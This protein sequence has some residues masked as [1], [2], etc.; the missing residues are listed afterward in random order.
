MPSPYAPRAVVC[1]GLRTPALSTDEQIN[2][3]DPSIATVKLAGR[4]RQIF[5]DKLW[6]AAAR[7][8][9]CSACTS[10]YGSKSTAH[11]LCT[12]LRVSPRYL[13]RLRCELC[14]QCDVVMSVCASLPSHH[15]YSKHTCFRKALTVDRIHEY[16]QWLQITVS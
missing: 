15:M 5:C 12:Q 2:V 3:D 14:C 9:A 7:R 13:W 6:C 4:I 11:E 16:N 8:R 1:A 10:S